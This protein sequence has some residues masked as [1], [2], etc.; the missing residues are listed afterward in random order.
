[1]IGCGS[2][3]HIR[4][5]REAT[6]YRGHLY[7]DPSLEIFNAAGLASGWSRTFHPRTLLKGVRAFASGFRQGVRRGNP[8]QQGGTFVLGP[9][10]RTRYE[11]RD[12]FAGDH[13]ALGDV[14]AALER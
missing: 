10:A 11:W 5:F 7:T 1:M 4:G 6:R 2:P 14:L 3:E 12:R 9:G 13:P 8:V